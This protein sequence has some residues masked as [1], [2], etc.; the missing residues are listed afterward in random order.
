MK[1]GLFATPPR[2]P[3]SLVQRLSPDAA[4]SMPLDPDISRGTDPMESEGA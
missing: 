2:N 1:N 3:L 4:K